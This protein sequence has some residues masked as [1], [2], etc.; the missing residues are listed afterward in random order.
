MVYKQAE[1]FYNVLNLCKSQLQNPCVQRIMRILEIIDRSY[2]PSFKA[3]TEAVFDG[4]AH[5][6][7][8]TVDFS[9]V[10]PTT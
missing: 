3:L 1:L 7:L 6:I 8:N 2:V 9:T 5:L 4:K 10:L